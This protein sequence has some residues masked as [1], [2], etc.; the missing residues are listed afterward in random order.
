MTTACPPD[1]LGY[2]PFATREDLA[3]DLVESY[4]A[5]ATIRELVASRGIC[6]G[7]VQQLLREG[8]AV[9]RPRGSTRH[10]TP[11]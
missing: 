9:M 5:G 4:E 1:G 3:R 11:A 8:D 7:T 10:P 6:F 2:W